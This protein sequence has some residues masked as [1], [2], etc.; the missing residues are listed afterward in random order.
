MVDSASFTR[1]PFTY[2]LTNCLR[3]AGVALFLVL[4]IRIAATAIA[5]LLKG[6]AWLIKGAISLGQWLGGKLAPHI[7]KIG[8]VL[9]YLRTPI[10][11]VACAKCRAADEG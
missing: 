1:M 8:T 5:W 10:D 11:L 7:S 6:F 9:G 2:A 3:A 4:P